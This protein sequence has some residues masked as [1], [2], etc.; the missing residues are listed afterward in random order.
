VYR[1]FSESCDEGPTASSPRGK[2]AIRACARHRRTQVSKVIHDSFGV[3]G[4]GSL[5]P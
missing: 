4:M 3:K 1:L 5:S 2:K